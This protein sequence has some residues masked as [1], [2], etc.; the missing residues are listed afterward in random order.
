MAD[1]EILSQITDQ[2]KSD[3][4][5]MA[6]LAYIGILVFIPMFTSKQNKFVMFH[7]EQGLALFIVS[8]I[9][10]IFGGIID[11]ALYNTVSISIPCFGGLVGGLLRL[12]VFILMI[13]GIINA[14]GGK[15]QKLPVIGDFGAKFNLVK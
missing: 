10:W 9:I 6:I 2:E 13:M 7:V 3:G 4:K 8:I 15:V 14:A 5:I 1:R 11:T 12:F